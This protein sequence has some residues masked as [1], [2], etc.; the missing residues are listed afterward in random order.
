MMLMML[1]LFFANNNKS[2]K[3]LLILEKI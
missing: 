3:I 2:N 1:G